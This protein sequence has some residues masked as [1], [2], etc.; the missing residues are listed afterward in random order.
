MITRFLA[1]TLAV[2][3]AFVCSSYGQ[4]TKNVRD[5]VGVTHVAGRYHL[6][7]KDFLSEGA[8]QILA[9]GSRVI[10]VWFYSGKQSEG[11]AIPTRTIPSGRR[12]HHSSPGL[13]RRIS[14]SFSTSPSPPIS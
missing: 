5:V 12:S 2:N 3:S 7:D 14:R 9:L 1:V 10:K 8:D 4:G 13:S 6:T 11:P